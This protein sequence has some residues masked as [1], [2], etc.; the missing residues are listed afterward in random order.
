MEKAPLLSPCPRRLGFVFATDD[1]SNGCCPAAL[2]PTT[3]S[4]RSI[5]FEFK[6][7]DGSR[8]KRDEKDDVNLRV[9]FGRNRLLAP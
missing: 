3:W 8:C 7:R 2:R 9:R 4:H 1:M 6:M 5:Y